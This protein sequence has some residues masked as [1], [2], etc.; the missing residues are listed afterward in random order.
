MVS[1]VFNVIDL[2]LSNDSKWFLY[3]LLALN[4]LSNLSEPLA[5]KNEASSK[6]GTVGKTGKAIP[7]IPRP[8]DIKPNTTYMYL[9]YSSY[10]NIVILNKLIL[11][12]IRIL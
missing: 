12:K 10:F 11:I 9:I 8:S 1:L 5:K 4:H 7:T 3:I 6:N 2:S